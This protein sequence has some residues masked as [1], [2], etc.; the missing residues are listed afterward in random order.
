M[1][2]LFGSSIFHN[3]GA[4]DSAMYRDNSL[5]VWAT[6][7]AGQ[8]GKRRCSDKPKIKLLELGLSHAAHGVLVYV[9]HSTMMVNAR[10]LRQCCRV[11]VRAQ[12]IA[13]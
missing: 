4:V 11:T 6:V 12:V 13:A 8:V 3:T 7:N 9:A 5:S 1:Q 2:W 10:V